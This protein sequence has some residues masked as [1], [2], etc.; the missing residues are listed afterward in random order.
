MRYPNL[1]G[2]VEVYQDGGNV[3]EYLR[4]TLGE[5][6]NTDAIIE[7]AYDLQAGSYVRH[8]QQH[9]AA[10]IA[11]IDEISSVLR[12]HIRPGDTIL[13]VGTGE[14]TTLVGVAERCFATTKTILACDIS[15]SRLNVGRQFAAQNL[16]GCQPDLFAASFFALPLADKSVDV[17]WTSHAVE[18]NGGREREALAELFRV[19]RRKVC[20]FEPCYEANSSEGRERMDRLGYIRGLAA[21]AESLGASIEDCVRIESAFNP[22]NPTYAFVVT[23]P[24][25]PSAAHLWACPASHHALVSKAGFLYCESC[26]LAYPVLLDIPILRSEAAILAT[27]LLTRNHG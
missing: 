13:D 26:G 5:T 16:S 7:I 21:A 9:Y 25:R 23:P 17:I 1:A 10:M 19:A 15:W 27:G 6:S 8:F 3:T 14:C 11:Y 2:A 20:L 24:T 4:Q 22:L 12:D 18:P